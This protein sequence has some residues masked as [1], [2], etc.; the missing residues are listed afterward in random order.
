M[1]ELWKAFL[2]RLIHMLT[3]KLPA[4]I[5][6]EAPE[7]PLKPGTCECSHAR[8]AHRDGKGKCA[9]GFKPH[10]DLNDTDGWLYCGCQCFI[11]KRDDNDGEDE[12]RTPSPEELEKL[13]N[14]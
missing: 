5:I 6:V 3:P 1:K 13:Y 12:P 9:A 2:A 14:R 10:S 4:P 7:Q 11:P 8:C